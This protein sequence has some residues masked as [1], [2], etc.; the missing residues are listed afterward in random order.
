MREV[1]RARLVGVLGLFFGLTQAYL[2]S[3]DRGRPVVHVILAA[4]FLAGG[5]YILFASRRR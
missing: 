2:W 1:N 5:I 3:A 4:V